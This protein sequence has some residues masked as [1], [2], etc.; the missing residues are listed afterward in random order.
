MPADA[1]WESGKVTR[2]VKVGEK[3]SLK[4]IEAEKDKETKARSQ[5]RQQGSGWLSTDG[6]QTDRTK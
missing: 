4:V 3:S 5:A 6:G 1:S 2:M